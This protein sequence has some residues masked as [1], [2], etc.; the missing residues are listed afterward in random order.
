MKRLDSK[1]S[2]LLMRSIDRIA[3]LDNKTKQLVYDE[4]GYALGRQGGSAIQYW[5]YHGKSPSRLED[6]ENLAR[7]I[8]QRGGWENEL[9]LRAYLEA[10]GHH[11]PEQFSRQLMRNS[12]EYE[13][14]PMDGDLVPRPAFVVG[15]PILHPHLFFGRDRE[16]KRIFTLIN[17]QAMQNIIITGLERSGKTSLLHYLRKITR[18]PSSALRPDQFHEWLPQPEQFNW[19]YID[20]QDPRVYTPEG[21]M[22]YILRSL[23]FPV[24]KPCS[25]NQFVDV[26]SSYLTKPTVLLMDE[27]QVALAN[28]EF[29]PRVWQSLRSLISNLTEGRLAIVATTSG[30]LTKLAKDHERAVLLLNIFGYTIDLGP[31]TE[32]EA[33]QLIRS[34]PTPFATEDT[35]WI[36]VN[37]GRWPALVQLLCSTRLENIMD[38]DRSDG[39]KVEGLSRI[40]PYQHL[41]NQV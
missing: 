7:V 33:L 20:F 26:I 12:I 6:V 23:N 27:F 24:P 31:L 17:G 10:A 40:Q 41:L 30:S 9:E 34:S 21:L 16:L 32:D 35:D 1:A 18:T 25:L 4:L 5:V 3:Y 8:T 22:T 29:T 36:M 2:E 15:P 11:A 38:G 39:W 19:S 13:A 37:S 14:N 28:P